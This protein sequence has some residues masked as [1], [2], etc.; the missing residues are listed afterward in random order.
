MVYDFS[1]FF[2]CPFFGSDSCVGLCPS[3]DFVNVT[4]AKDGEFAGSGCT[5]MLSQGTNEVLHVF[6]I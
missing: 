4:A 3:H 2:L 5:G 6:S 1:S